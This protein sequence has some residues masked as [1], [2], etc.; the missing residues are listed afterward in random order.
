MRGT[1][2]EKRAIEPTLGLEGPG[3]VAP[4]L[5]KQGV[6]C[7]SAEAGPTPCSTQGEPTQKEP[8]PEACHGGDLGSGLKPITEVEVGDMPC[9]NKIRP[10]TLHQSPLLV[11]CP[12]LAQTP[13]F[14][15]C[16]HLCHIFLFVTRFSLLPSCILTIVLSGPGSL[17]PC[18]DPF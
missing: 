7:S 5:P 12:A 1:S 4:S 17:L 3:P 11:L 2:E 15:L 6:E 10:S 8:S 14:V 18:Q 9:R 13:L 16:V